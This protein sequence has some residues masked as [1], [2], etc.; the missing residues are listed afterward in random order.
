[1]RSFCAMEKVPKPERKIGENRGPKFDQR[2]VGKKA[3]STTLLS[4]SLSTPSFF[5]L[6]SPLPP[7]AGYFLLLRGK[8]K[9]DENAIFK[10]CWEWLFKAAPPPPPSPGGGSLILQCVGPSFFAL[11]EG[12]GGGRR[13]TYWPVAVSLPWQP[14]PERRRRRN[15]CFQSLLLSS[16]V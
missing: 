8:G 1:M 16:T 3:S 14:S 4:V 12:V 9:G 13:R 2:G 5:L 7:P 6:F 10:Y 11:E 15:V